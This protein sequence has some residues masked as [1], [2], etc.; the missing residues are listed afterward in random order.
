[1]KERFKNLTHLLGF[2]ILG[3]ALIAVYKTFDNLQI[4]GDFI[5]RIFDILSPFVTGFVLAFLLFAPVR[6]LERKYAKARPGPIRRHARA[7]SVLTVYVCLFALLALLLTFAIP[8]IIDGVRSLIA[9]LPGYFDQFMAALD[10]LTGEGGLLEG[11]NISDTLDNL[12][13]AYILP[14]LKF[15]NAP[16][17]FKGLMSFTSSLL[18]VF[19]ALIISVYMLLG[20][21]SLVRACKLVFSLFIPARPLGVLSK[22]SRKA[23]DIL[24]N[25]LYS[26][27][28]DACIVSVIMTIGCFIFRTPVPAVLGFMIGLMNMIP[29]FGAIIGG[30]AAVAISLLSGNLYGSIFLAIYIIGMQQLDANV[31][32]PRI[33]GDRVGI[34]PIYVLLAIT[35]GG[36][37]LGFWGIFLGVPMIAIVQMILIDLI[38]YRHRRAGAAQAKSANGAAPLPHDDPPSPVDSGP[39]A[40]SPSLS[41]PAEALSEGAAPSEPPCSREGAGEIAPTESSS[42]VEISPEESS[43]EKASPAPSPLVSWIRK[44]RKNRD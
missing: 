21:E 14:L 31:L 22:Y 33:V 23:C 25:Y 1:M 32:Q 17:Y 16:T 29:Y 26:Q 10:S 19:M 2:F 38:R 39:E 15:E 30:V 41:E 36:G 40:A 24:Y 3:V 8:A 18:N 5:W 35:L 6:F 20:R 9:A 43:P 34:K 11:L 7:F 42:R 37:L 44:F 4:I 27:V 28:L 12:Y 13:R